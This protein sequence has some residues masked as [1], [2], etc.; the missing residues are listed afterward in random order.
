M[1]TL[2][3]IFIIYTFFSITINI[4]ASSS[5]NILPKCCIGSESFGVNSYSLG[6]SC[7]DMVNCCPSGTY[8]VKEGKCVKNRNKK[9][10]RKIKKSK[11]KKNNDDIAEPKIEA[12]TDKKEEKP[13]RF[14]GPVRINW[15]TLNQCLIESKSKEP[16]IKE[17][18][19]DYKKKKESDAM[20][21]VFSE[22]KKNSPII[23][24]CL[25][26]QEHLQ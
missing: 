17:I 13:K 7:L 21:K 2:K 14:N 26:K 20:K 22:L 6:M 25:N 19:D 4:I 16:I 1:E 18:L 12:E 5:S 23:I 3:L 15:K 8:C 10:K 9:M 24:E 11:I